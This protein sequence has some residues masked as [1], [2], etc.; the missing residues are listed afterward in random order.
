MYFP[1]EQYS[2]TNKS[3]DSRPSEKCIETAQFFVTVLPP[4]IT[5]PHT[6][7]MSDLELFE[8]FAANW[9]SLEDDADLK[10]QL[11]FRTEGKMELEKEFV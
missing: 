1:A 10:T 4:N 7:D 3:A 6:K 9:S 5:G 11:S 2:P 8:T